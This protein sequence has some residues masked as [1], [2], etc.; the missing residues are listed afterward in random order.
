MRVTLIFCITF[1]LKLLVLSELNLRLCL[2]FEL[3][4]NIMEKK[5]INLIRMIN[6]ENNYDIYN[7]LYIIT[8]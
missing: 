5:N 1:V 8:Y 7:S 4:E 2:K 3:L 6:M